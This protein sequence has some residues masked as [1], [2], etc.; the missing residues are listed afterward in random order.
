MGPVPANYPTYGN[1]II[2]RAG[3]TTWLPAVKRTGADGIDRYTAYSSNDGE[4]WTRGGTWQHNLLRRVY[5]P[6]H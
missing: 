2:G 5:R 4:H 1:M 6:K 3:Q